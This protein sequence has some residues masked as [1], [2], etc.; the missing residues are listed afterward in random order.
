MEI[1][2][3]TQAQSNLLEIIEHVTQSHEPTYIVGDKGKTVLISEC[4]YRAMLE[5]L[6]LTSIPG[7]KDSIINASKEPIEHFAESIDWDNV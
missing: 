1:Y 2:T 4:D 3:A 7:I 6:H 5:T